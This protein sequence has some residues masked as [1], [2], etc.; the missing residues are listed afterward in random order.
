MVDRTTRRPPRGV[1]PR[2]LLPS[3]PVC[4]RT[5][6]R[7]ERGAAAR[8]AHAHTRTHT[9]HHAPSR[10]SSSERESEKKKGAGPSKPFN[11]A[12]STRSL[13]PPFLFV[14]V[15]FSP[16][17]ALR[18]APLSHAPLPPFLPSFLQA[19]RE[20]AQDGG[21]RNVS[22]SFAASAVNMSRGG[23]SPL[24]VSACVMCNPA[25]KQVWTTADE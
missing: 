3:L 4:H 17:R 10:S 11:A 2:G 12:V 20:G 5:M 24:S 21:A 9:Q 23:V 14:C 13:T 15:C 25:R 8:W 16:A 18:S 7:D 6:R 22:L 1:Q 19:M